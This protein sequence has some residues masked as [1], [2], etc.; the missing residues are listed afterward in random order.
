V[1]RE[2]EFDFNERVED[3]A[4]EPVLEDAAVDILAAQV[5]SVAL[6][7]SGTQALVFCPQPGD[8]LGRPEV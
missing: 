5:R 3:A 7:A 1:E 4:A 2:D 8:L 6:A